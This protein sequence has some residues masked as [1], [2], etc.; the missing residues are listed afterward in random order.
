MSLI[1]DKVKQCVEAEASSSEWT[2]K[3]VLPKDHEQLKMLDHPQ[4]LKGVDSVDPDIVKAIRKSISARSWADALLVMLKN[5]V[6]NSWDLNELSRK[7]FFACLSKSMML[8]GASMY[9][10]TGGCP[11]WSIL[12]YGKRCNWKR[13]SRLIK[14][15]IP[16]ISQFLKM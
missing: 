13:K 10:P 7:P 14:R 1:N 5:E 11:K 3:V 6:S 15:K 4:L 12:Q 9:R 2:S 8:I 16:S